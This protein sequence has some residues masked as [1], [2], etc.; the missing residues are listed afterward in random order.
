MKTNFIVL[1][2]VGFIAFV[3]VLY[4]YVDKVIISNAQVAELEQEL[5]KER[6]TANN[7]NVVNDVTQKTLS[8]YLKA[9]SEDIQKKQKEIEKLAK[10]VK[11][12]YVE[13][14]ST[15]PSAPITPN[16]SKPSDKCLFTST[17]LGQIKTERIESVTGLGNNLV[18]MRA[19]AIN[20]T[21]GYSL[22]SGE[23]KLDGVKLE[24]KPPKDPVYL[25]VVAGIGQHGFVYGLS[26]VGKILSFNLPFNLATVDIASS[27]TILTGPKTSFEIQGGLLIGVQ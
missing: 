6:L 17:D 25:G 1:V 8:I 22:F 2:M 16:L 21:T 13:S 10:N 23:L 14:G 11:I 3:A 20:A 15:T 7:I 9:L 27:V 19:T 5:E 18:L 24:S 26:G 4:L 12:V